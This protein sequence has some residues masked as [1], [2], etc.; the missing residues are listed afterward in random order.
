MGIFGSIKNAITGPFR[1]INELA[2][3]R[4]RGAI[5]AL[6]D[7]VK[8]AGVILGAT[9][10]GLPVAAGV[11]ALGGA[12]QKA[13]D[14]GNR[15]FEDIVGGAAEGGMLGAGSALAPIAVDKLGGLS[16]IANYAKS[17]PQTVLQGLGTA[18]NMYGSY[19]QGRA[20]DDRLAA[21]QLYRDQQARLDEAERQ[22]RF[23]LS[24]LNTLVSMMSATRPRY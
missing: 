2:H 4:P 18:S 9:G 17:N 12:M 8:P 10:V 21:D 5:G 19:E 1:A 7:T 22:R 20:Y 24:K 13:D 3:G 6:G 11:S 16:A 14:V 15:G 23:D